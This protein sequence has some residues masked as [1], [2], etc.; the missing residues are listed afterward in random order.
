MLDKQK[1]IKIICRLAIVAAICV[2]MS[3]IAFK[4]LGVKGTPIGLDQ[5]SVVVGLA[6]GIAV[7]QIGK[8]ISQCWIKNPSHNNGNA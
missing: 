6:I 2:V 7:S 1:L 5:R 4:I 3:V 8:M